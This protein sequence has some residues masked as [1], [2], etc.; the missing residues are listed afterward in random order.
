MPVSD[1]EKKAES[2]SMINSKLKS[3]SIDTSFKTG[4]AYIAERPAILKEF[5]A[6][7]NPKAGS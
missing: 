6:F 5:V 1:P 7:I 2:S 4:R 3:S